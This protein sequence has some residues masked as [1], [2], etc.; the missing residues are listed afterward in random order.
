MKPDECVQT[1][2]LDES[3]SDMLLANFEAKF[4]LV[5]LLEMS[6]TS[7]KSYSWDAYFTIWRL[8]IIITARLNCLF[9]LLV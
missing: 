3:Y 7:P 1:S 5:I 2:A 6:V 9:I 8:I 4:L